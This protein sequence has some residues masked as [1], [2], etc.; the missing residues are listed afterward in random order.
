MKQGTSVHKALEEEVHVTVPITTPSKEDGWGLRVWNIIQGI[1]TLR[2]TGFTREMEVWGTVGGEIVNGVIDE[3]SYTCPDPNLESKVDKQ[4]FKNPVA[5]DLP[6]RQ[7]SITD[8]LAP[9]S[10]QE[11][12]QSLEAAL[13]PGQPPK[14]KRIYVT[15]I[16]TRGSKT[17]PALTAMRP[18]ILQLH[19]YH[20]MLENLAQ[21]NLSLQQLAERYGLDITAAFSDEFIAQVGSLNQEMSELRDSQDSL[22]ILLEHNNLSSLWSYMLGEFRETFFTSAGSELPTSTP[23]SVADLPAPQAQP[24][25]LSPILTVEY[26]SATYEHRRGESTHQHSLGRKS[27]VF[28]APYLKAYLEDSLT[29]WHGEREAKGVELQE[30]WKCR[31]CDFRNDCVWIHDRDQAAFDQA[32]DRK[33]MRA[34]AYGTKSAV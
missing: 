13:G 28:N 6:E 14:E 5:P 24:T 16:K 19:L 3:I 33:T 34:E 8:F 9:A 2:D 17:L 23:Q 4:N 18:A 26:L 25:R 31:S 12:G 20:H 22:D 30:A 7:T 29:W 11:N 27:F 15:D 10:Q 1:R 32:M 21:G